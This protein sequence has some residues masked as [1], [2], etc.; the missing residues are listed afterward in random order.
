MQTRR[1]QVR[2]YRFVTRRIISALL[3]GEPETNDLP[4]RRLG[5]A[6]LASLMVGGI[7]FAIVGVY[8]LLNPGGGQL[9]GNALVIERETG[10]RYVYLDDTLYPVLNYS[11]AW[12]SLGVADPDVRN[13]TCCSL[14]KIK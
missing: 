4:M 10:A 11:S 14:I 2:A 6:L 13:V 1:E 3:A 9:D 12:L 8:G 5:G 7:V